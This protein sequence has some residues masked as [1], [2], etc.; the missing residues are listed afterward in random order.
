MGTKSVPAFWILL[1]AMGI[2]LIYIVV[3]VAISPQGKADWA[4]A[5][6]GAGSFTRAASQGLRPGG[7]WWPRVTWQPN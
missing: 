4:A 3:L 1:Y 5:T 7:S 2:V 6:Q